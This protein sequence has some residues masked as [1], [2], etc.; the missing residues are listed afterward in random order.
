VLASVVVATS[1]FLAGPGRSYARVVFFDVGQGDSTLL[2]LPRRQYVLVDAGP[3]PASAAQ[4]GRPSVRDAGSDVVLR[5][6]RREGVTRLIALVVTHAHADHYGGAVSVL[7]G[8][9]VD[10]LILP[11]GRS[12]DVRLTNLIAVARRRGTCVR[13][14]SWGET[15]RVGDTLL[16]VLWPDPAVT[17]EWSENNC[18]VVLRGTVSGHDLM[19]TGDIENRAESRLCTMPRLLPAGLLKVPH[20]G[21]RTSSTEEFVR[22]VSPELAVVQVGERNR[23]GHPDQQ[24][25]DRL[26]TAGAFVVRTDVDGAV[27]VDLREGRAVARCVVSGRECVLR[28]HGEGTGASR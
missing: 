1:L 2:E 25:L 24:T 21:S 16:T 27:V 3:G 22:R 20:H 4:T 23:Y 9:R 11:V 19:L 18:S 8:V 15:L 7:L 28:G 26:E 13:E 5:H 6:L 12:S 17:A 14:V 10:T